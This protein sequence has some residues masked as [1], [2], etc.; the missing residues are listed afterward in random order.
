MS[1]CR[2]TASVVALDALVAQVE[3]DERDQFGAAGQIIGLDVDEQRTRDGIAAVRHRLDARSHTL[4][5]VDLY[6]RDS[7]LIAV[8]KAN[9]TQPSEVSLPQ[10][11][12]MMTLSFGRRLMVNPCEVVVLAV[13]I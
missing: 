6:R 5:A 4:A 10:H 12:S 11:S 13:T 3:V 2:R 1:G 7:A 8:K 9:P